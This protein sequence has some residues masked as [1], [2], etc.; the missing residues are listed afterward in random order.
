MIRALR[1]RERETVGTVVVVLIFLAC[2]ANRIG[3]PLVHPHKTAARYMRQYAI[4][5]L[6]AV[7][8][9]I[10]TEVEKIANEPSRLRPTP[11]IC[12]FNSYV[13]KRVDA[14]SRVQ[15]AILEKT[16]KISDSHVAKAK[17]QRVLP[18]VDQFINP[19]RLEF[20]PHVN[21]R[22]RWHNGG[23]ACNTI[24]ADTTGITS[25]LPLIGGDN[26]TFGGG[27]AA[28]R[29]GCFSCV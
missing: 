26:L 7:C 24:Q 22:V 23:L 16:D 18:D 2:R 6:S 12:L 19:P 27:I 14:A 15:V 21:V 20:T 25:E 29:Q 17:Y 10:V 3:K 9:S 1:I 8:V 5:N 4:K 28:L 11:A 13:S